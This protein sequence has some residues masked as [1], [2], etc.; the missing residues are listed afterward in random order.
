MTPAERNQTALDLLENIKTAARAVAQKTGRH[1]DV[2]TAELLAEGA[3]RRP[4][5]IAWLRVVIPQVPELAPHLLPHF[6]NE[7]WLKETVEQK[8]GVWPKKRSK[9]DYLDDAFYRRDEALDT[10]LA[11][12]AKASAPGADYR[13]RLGELCAYAEL[14]AGACLLGKLNPAKAHREEQLIDALA[15]ILTCLCIP[16][17]AS[18]E[19]F[20]GTQPVWGERPA[21]VEGYYLT[22]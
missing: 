16:D 13:D 19:P 1:H 18:A 5:D 12:K 22:G 3:T 6:P 11:C 9:A 4:T 2:I 14:Y 21:G 8:R 17:G 7:Q 20:E 15:T 10:W